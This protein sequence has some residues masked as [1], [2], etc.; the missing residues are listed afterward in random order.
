MVSQIGILVLISATSCHVKL[1]IHPPFFAVLLK[2]GAASLKGNGYQE[3]LCAKTLL[4][5]LLNDFIFQ[6]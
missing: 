5:A 1:L 6:I 4:V 3:G 2:N